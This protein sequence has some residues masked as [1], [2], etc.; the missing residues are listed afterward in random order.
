MPGSLPLLPTS[1]LLSP[2]RDLKLPPKG[3]HR[4]G[5]RGFQSRAEGLAR[6]LPRCWS[7]H[8]SLASDLGDS[9]H[10]LAY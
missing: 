3:A 9:S 4:L 5:R 10:S 1:A 6:K 7:P 8:C 2:S